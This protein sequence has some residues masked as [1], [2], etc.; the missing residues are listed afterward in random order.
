MSRAGA[1]AEARRQRSCARKR[2]FAC[3]AAAAQEA[4][5]IMAR[6]W[7]CLR[8]YACPYCDVF[9]LTHTRKVV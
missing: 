6:G 1:V 8:V 2:R 9:H 3:E 4:A 5:K 7:S